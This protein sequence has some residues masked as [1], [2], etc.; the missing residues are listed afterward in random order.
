[1]KDLHHRTVDKTQ[2]RSLTGDNIR[3]IAYIKSED[4]G[5]SFSNPVN[6]SD[7]NWKLMA[8]PHNGPSI[9]QTA[10]G[11]MTLWYTAGGEEGLYFAKAG[12][13]GEANFSDRIKVSD[14]AKQPYIASMGNSALAI[15]NEIYDEDEEN[16]QRINMCRITSDGISDKQFLSPDGVDAAMPTYLKTEDGS[17]IVTWRQSAE[18]GNELYFTVMPAAG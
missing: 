16:Y 8:C 7:D 3:D 11:L 6:V 14:Q 10:N 18:N 13:G 5:S 9:T 15:W 2:Y 1:M 12:I 4:F 17:V